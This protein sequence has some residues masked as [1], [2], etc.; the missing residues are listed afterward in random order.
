MH[1]QS[2]RTAAMEEN[3]EAHFEIVASSAV[4][5]LLWLGPPAQGYSVLHCLVTNES[6]F[7]LMYGGILR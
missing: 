4:F 5:A 3:I 2:C 6:I 7:R 1:A